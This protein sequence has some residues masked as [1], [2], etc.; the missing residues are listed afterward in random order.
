M[1]RPSRNIVRARLALGATLSLA[2]ASAFAHPGHDAATVGASLWA[3]LLH[4]FTGLD[5]LLAMTAV[6]VWSAQTAQ[7][8]SVLRLPLAFVLLMLVGAALGLGGLALP[9]VEPMIAASLLVL[10]LLVAARAALPGP[11]GMA[12]VGGFALFHGYAHGA[13]LPAAAAALPATLA[14]V[15]GFACAT[16]AL[17]LSGI[18]LGSAL[19][20]QGGWLMRAA[21]A[22]VALYGIGLLA[23]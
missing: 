11:A 20:R 8:G 7:G 9:A 17:H 3:G 21:G 10:G 14:Y 5:H 23:A 12:V 1:N 15:A 22:G 2:A 4:P 19:R 13:E 18:G 16:M 6:G